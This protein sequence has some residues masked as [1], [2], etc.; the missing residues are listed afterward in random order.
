[1]YFEEKQRSA[2]RHDRTAAMKL[3][4]AA[5]KLSVISSSISHGSTQ[6]IKYVPDV[7]SEIIN[8]A[9]A[10][11]PSILDLF[12]RDSSLKTPNMPQAQVSPTQVSQPQVSQAPQTSVSQFREP[13]MYQEQNFA[14]TDS[15]RKQVTSDPFD[16]VNT[17]NHPDFSNQNDSAL[18]FGGT[19]DNI[20]AGN[21]SVNDNYGDKS[22]VTE[23]SA[24]KEAE[25]V[26]KDD[27]YEALLLA[28]IKELEA[29]RNNSVK[30][31]ELFPDEK[32][33]SES[34]DS[35]D[36]YTE[37]PKNS[38]SEEIHK[39][40]EDDSHVKLSRTALADTEEEETE[41]V[42]EKRPRRRTAAERTESNESSEVWKQTKRKASQSAEKTAEDDTEKKEKKKKA[43]KKSWILPVVL[44]VLMIILAISIFA[45]IKTGTF[46]RIFNKTDAN[47]AIYS[48]GQPVA[49]DSNGN[50]IN[51]TTSD[52]SVT[53][54]TVV[55]NQVSDP[56]VVNDNGN[57][58]DGT[59]TSGTTTS[60]AIANGT[61]TNGSDTNGTDG[62]GTQA[63]ADPTQSAEPTP[64]TEQ[65]LGTAGRLYFDNG[66]SVALN[67]STGQEASRTQEYTDAQDSAVYISD[68]GKIMIAD[69]ANQGFDIIKEYGIGSTARIKGPDGTERNI[70]C[71]AYYD[72]AY[73]DNGYTYLP[74]G[75]S[76]WDA[77]DGEIGMQTSNN[78]SGTS[79]TIS[80]WNYT[81]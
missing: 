68:N 72:N 20:S 80:Y 18:A 3:Q 19:V 46:A 41:P 24:V 23:E 35:A 70:V 42:R 55:N 8:S 74:D 60:G 26:K 76:I 63:S 16:R 61:V 25:P 1:M 81:N 45:G 43:G 50:V 57:N 33:V 36:D 32:R 40:A 62:T 47:Q 65:T 12:Y 44:T 30:S 15:S 2:D 13:Q 69:H 9:A 39:E 31:E 29:Y 28:K 78:E 59:T 52:G 56:T 38:A 75:R 66:W 6:D 10:L 48:D 34:P 67:D 79:I 73:W 53:D 77:S 71:T 22:S 37:D 64:E 51:G 5:S 21:K 11:D 17:Q 54:P 7:I 14:A 49:I 58:A 27:E 4:A